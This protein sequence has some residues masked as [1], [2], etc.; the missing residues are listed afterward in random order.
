MKSVTIAG[1]ICALVA[2]AFLP[3]GF[4]VLGM[5]LGVMT[6]AKGRADHGLA[7]IVLAAVCGY[8]GMA[9]SLTFW[10]KV[11]V[12]HWFAEAI[13]PAPAIG[14]PHWQ[15]LSLETR[16]TKTSDTDP[17]CSWK[18]TVK[19]D[20]L[21]SGLFQGSIEFQDNN[22]IKLAEDTVQGTQ[23]AAGTIGVFTGSV[24]IKTSK[25]VARAVPQIPNSG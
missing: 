22:G 18:L 10:G 12:Q 23:V 9:S 4:G 15:I 8:Y 1:G 24:A 20:S 19:N 5:L 6:L 11:P 7:V 13:A 25:R 14:T 16:V 17:V 21:Q 3:A 2:L